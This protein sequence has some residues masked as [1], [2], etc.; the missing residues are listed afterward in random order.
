ML[1][2]DWPWWGADTAPREIQHYRQE[3]PDLKLPCD[4]RDGSVA[5]QVDGHRFP[6]GKE[7]RTSYPL[8]T[9]MHW[10]YRAPPFTKEGEEIG[11]RD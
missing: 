1:L 2:C 7:I 8:P 5:I 4:L 9:L 10:H 3:S 11:H 6:Y